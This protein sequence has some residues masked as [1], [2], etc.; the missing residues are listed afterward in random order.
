M[1]CLWKEKGQCHFGFIEH[2][3]IYAGKFL[4]L[5]CKGRSAGNDFP[6]MG[7]APVY[8]VLSTFF[9]DNHRAQKNHV[10]P[11]KMLIIKI[12]RNEVKQRSLFSRHGPEIIFDKRRL[13]VYLFFLN[14][15]AKHNK[16]KFVS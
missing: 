16:N 6:A 8:D 4:V 12:S 9:L 10:R 5:C 14:V 15:P 3:M 13:H 2:K 1:P 11:G 7:P